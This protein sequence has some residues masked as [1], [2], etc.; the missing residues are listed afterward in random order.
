M[1]LRVWDSE[2]PAEHLST[3]QRFQFNEDWHEPEECIYDFDG[4]GVVDANA[5]PY[6]M[7][8]W[9]TCVTSNLDFDL[10][11]DGDVDL[12]DYYAAGVDEAPDVYNNL[13]TPEY[14][15]IYDFNEDGV[16]NGTADLSSGDV[17]VAAN[18]MLG[19]STDTCFCDEVMVD[20]NIS[21]V[22]GL[23]P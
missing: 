7:L 4:N 15:S 3:Y 22:S 1:R 12:A 17:A 11:E 8:L 19:L 5:D 20:P 9:R 6:Y 23:Y 10:D 18:N 13:C 21:C 14:L 16:V 2:R